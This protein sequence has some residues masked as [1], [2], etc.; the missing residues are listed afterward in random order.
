MFDMYQN[1]CEKQN[2]KLKLKKKKK[3]NLQ[4]NSK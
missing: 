2:T 4:I 1:A 3:K